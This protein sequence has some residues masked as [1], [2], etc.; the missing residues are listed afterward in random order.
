MTGYAL[1]GGDRSSD[2]DCTVIGVG[3]MRSRTE[4]YWQGYVKGISQRKLQYCSVLC[5]KQLRLGFE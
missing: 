4:C 5:Y 2:G 3:F 1:R